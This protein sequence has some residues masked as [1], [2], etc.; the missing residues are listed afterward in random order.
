VSDLVFN[1]N[2]V[3][4]GHR[5]LYALR[6]LLF[7]HM[8][9]LSMGFYDRN[10][11]GRVMSRVQN[12]VQQLQE[13]LNI[14]AFT[15]AH[16]AGLSGVIAAM[17]IMSWRL[18]LITLASVG[19]VVPV[20]I[21]WQRYA[22]ASFLRTR[23][24]IADVNAGLQENLSAVR[25]IQSLNRQ[26]ANMRLFHEVNRKNL[27]A[28]LQ[29]TRYIA[30]LWPSVD[31]ISSVGLALV[32]LFGG[33]MVLRGSFEVGVLVAFALYLQRFYEPMER[34]IRDY[35]QIQQA[36]VSVARTFEVLDIEPAPVN[37][38]DAVELDHVRGE[39]RYE[40]VDFA[41][42]PQ[43]RVLQDIDLTIK[44]GETVALVGPTGAGKTTLVSLLL[45]FY[46][47]SAGRITIDG[48]DVRDVSIESLSR[49]VSVVLQE[50]YLFSG[51]VRENIR[52]NSAHATDQDIERAA[53]AVGAHQF[54]TELDH[55]YETVLHERGGNLSVGQRQLLSFARALAAN[56]RVLVLDEAT[57]N[58]DT[59]TEMVIQN[60]LSELLAGRTAIVIAHRLS[61]V[62]SADRI[63]VVEE[64]RIV[65]Q[66]AHDELMA[67]DDRYARLVSATLEGRQ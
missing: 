55:G 38:P 27:G 9:R 60:A 64:G 14:A 54:V 15:V 48:H 63:V 22:S 25:V 36:A 23:E 12:D 62:R 1:R 51:T 32:V 40:G 53:R 65:E 2:L 66:G 17:L 49:Q 61:T 50:P 52:Y 31:A 13:L 16:A 41:Y 57:A 24:S 56:P 11:I 30:A 18:A 7:Q 42:D 10:Q 47:V 5:I 43:T 45:R 39:V 29:A 37:K 34:L 8:M 58:I 67:L 19:L 20:L 4:L 35:G 28:N 59:Y 21:F 46:D 3:V 26:K 44:P 6:V 33:T